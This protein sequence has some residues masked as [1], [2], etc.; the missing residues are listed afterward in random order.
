MR[1]VSLRHQVPAIVIAS[2]LVL[3]VL[4]QTEAHGM[5]QTTP[6]ARTNRYDNP[7]C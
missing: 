6:I 2:M 4:G 1:T 7:I 3:G 5:T